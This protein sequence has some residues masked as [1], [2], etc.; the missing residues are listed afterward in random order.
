MI[1]EQRMEIEL[2]GGFLIE[3]YWIPRKSC[4][5]M[6]LVMTVMGCL[7]AGFCYIVPEVL[8]CQTNRRLPF[9]IPNTY[10]TTITASALV[11]STYFTPTST[12]SQTTT[13]QENDSKVGNSIRPTTLT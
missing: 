10:L 8:V 1:P 3:C 9:M 7:T 2:F 6:N 12:I 5:L 4:R 11:F 13:P